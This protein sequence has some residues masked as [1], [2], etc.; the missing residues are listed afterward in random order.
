MLHILFCPGTFGS[1]VFYLIRYFDKSFKNFED[2]NFKDLITSDGSMHGFFKTGHIKTKQELTD[3]FE[4]RWGENLRVTSPIYPMPD[5][6]AH[7]IVQQF[8]LFKPNDRYVFLYVPDQK[9]AEINLLAMYHKI[10]NGIYS[11]L[12]IGKVF[13]N[14]DAITE[15]RQWNENYVSWKDME[16]WELR[17]WLSISWGINEWFEVQDIIPNNWLKISNKEI[18]ENT[19][20]TFLKIVNHHREFDQSKLDIFDQFVSHWRPKQQYLVDEQQLIT[21]IVDAVHTDK[22]LEWNKLNIIAEAMIQH[23]LRKLGYNL[24]CYGLNEFPTTSDQIRKVI[25]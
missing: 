13:C 2:E 1:T 6:T 24:K 3:F 10:A 17:E 14:K 18:L 21:D 23:N 5:I 16:V 4:G 7:E 9:Y 15:I 22:F 12:D 20:E 25:E 19:R 8:A 11:S